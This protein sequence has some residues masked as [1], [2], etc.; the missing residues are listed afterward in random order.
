MKKNL[1][2]IGF[3]GVGK[4]F[5]GKKVATHFDMGFIDT[6]HLIEGY[7]NFRLSIAEIYSNYGEKKFREF[8]K[9]VIKNIKHKQNYVIATGGGVVEIEGV[10]KYLRN[11]GAIVYLYNSLDILISRWEKKPRVIGNSPV[12]NLY[13]RR[14]NLYENI[15]DRKVKGQWDQILLENIFR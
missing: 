1:I 2:L 11:L 9:E 4:T 7:F 10:E 8:E 12:E 6:D 13:N 14:T 15:C 3:K 5:I